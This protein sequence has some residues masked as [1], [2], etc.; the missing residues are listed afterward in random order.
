[1]KTLRIWTKSLLQV[2]KFAHSRDIIMNDLYL[3]NFHFDGKMVSAFDWNHA[4]L[5]KENRTMLYNDWSPDINKIHPEV[6]EDGLAVHP[7][8]YSYDIFRVGLQIAFCLKIY[9]NIGLEYLDGG[10]VNITATSKEGQRL[11]K[12]VRRAVNLAR[13]MLLDDPLKRP[14]ARQALH[15][16]FIRKHGKERNRKS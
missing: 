1:M 13:W 4:L 11:D 9:F 3:Q 16:P 8:T 7:N 15:H 2:L 6:T 14:S 5:Y 10:G 12:D